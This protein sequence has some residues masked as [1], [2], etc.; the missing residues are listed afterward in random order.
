MT[1]AP[2]LVSEASMSTSWV[3]VSID[4]NWLKID[5]SLGLVVRAVQE[6]LGSFHFV[7]NVCKSSGMR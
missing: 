5:E 2:D 3:E 7:S 1:S 6:D 4:F